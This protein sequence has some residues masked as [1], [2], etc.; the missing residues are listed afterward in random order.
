MAKKIWDVVVMLPGT[1]HIP[2]NLRINL[3]R[4]FSEETVNNMTDEAGQAEISK[5]IT[6]YIMGLCSV[7]IK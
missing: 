2:L 4:H 5:I 3:T 1:G 6:E 7:T